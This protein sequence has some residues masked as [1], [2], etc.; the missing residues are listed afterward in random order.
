[1]N[2]DL[3]L[4]PLGILT[5]LLLLATLIGG[6]TRV[7]LQYHKLLAYTTLGVASLHGGLIIYLTYF[8]K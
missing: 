7:K 4:K 5:Y 3:W 6:L 1:M 8:A 2:I